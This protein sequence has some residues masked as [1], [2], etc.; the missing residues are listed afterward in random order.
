VYMLLLL[1][2]LQERHDI[3]FKTLEEKHAGIPIWSDGPSE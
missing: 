1:F 2:A 3:Q